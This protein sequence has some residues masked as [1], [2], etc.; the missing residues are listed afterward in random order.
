VH[1]RLPEEPVR[2]RLENE[3]VVE[4]LSVPLER[5]NGELTVVIGSVSAKEPLER[6]SPEPIAVIGSA[7]VSAPLET[8]SPVP[9]LVT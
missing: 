8:L 2:L 7:N 5:L 4:M 3:G 6:V 9:R 1:L